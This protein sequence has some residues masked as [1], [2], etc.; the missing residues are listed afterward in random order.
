MEV[1]IAGEERKG[2]ERR[3][4]KRGGRGRGRSD[5]ILLYDDITKTNLPIIGMT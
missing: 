4:E 3:E 2:S 1:R 5:N